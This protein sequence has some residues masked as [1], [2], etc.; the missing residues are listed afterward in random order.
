MGCLLAADALKIFQQGSRNIRDLQQRGLQGWADPT[1]AVTNP[2]V[3]WTG[4]TC[5]S[6]NRVTAL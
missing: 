1:G 5:D 4:V 6:T 3:G 2:C